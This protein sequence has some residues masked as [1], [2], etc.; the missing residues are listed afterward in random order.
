M[1]SKGKQLANFL[2]KP[3]SITKGKAAKAQIVSAAVRAE[4]EALLRPNEGVGGVRM[5]KNMAKSIRLLILVTV[6]I[7][8]SPDRLGR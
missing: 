3:D 1:H 2:K 6:Y 8:I 4:P 7:F 5:V